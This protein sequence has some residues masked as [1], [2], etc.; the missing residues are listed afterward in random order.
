MHGHWFVVTGQTAMKI[1]Q[2]AGTSR[3]LELLM[4]I[5]N[6]LGRARNRELIKKKAGIGVKY[7]GHASVR[8]S[9][10][11]RHDPHEEVISKFAK[12]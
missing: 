11:K 9:E 3:Q 5:D 8:H 12:K 7:V 4:D 1:Y 2:Q 6:P 10:T